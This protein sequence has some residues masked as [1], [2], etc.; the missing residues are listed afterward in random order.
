MSRK[1][2]SAEG[3]VSVGSYSHAVESGELIYL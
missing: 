3:A 1:A 2:F